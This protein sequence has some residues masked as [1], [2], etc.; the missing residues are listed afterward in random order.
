[1]KKIKKI[2][3][4]GHFGG[5][6]EFFDGQTIKTKV[7]CNTIKK[8]TDWKIKKVDTYLKA[9]SPIKLILKSIG[10]LLSTKRIVVLLSVNGMKFYFPILYFFAKVFRRKIF[11]DV[12]GGNLDV[13][14][15]KNPKFIKYLNS[16]E[17]NWVET[18]SM[19]DSLQSLEINNVKVLPN[20][21]ELDVVKEEELPQE[22][23][24]PFR[25]CT[26]SRVMKEK[27]IEDAIDAIERINRE[28]GR[29]VCTV[30]IYGNVDEGY[31]ERFDEIMKAT[32]SAVK[33]CGAVPFDK[34][35]EAIKEYYGLLFPTFWCGEGFAGTIV[36]AFSA[37]L[38]VIATDFN[39]NSEIVENNITGLLYPNE[40]QKNLY[41]CI[42]WAIENSNDFCKMKKKCINKAREYQP[43]KYIDWIKAELE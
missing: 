41:D 22:F 24:E 34:S 25:F 10:M 4:I 12:I 39:C 35:V 7:F 36:D 11:H 18:Q 6:E 13:L 32:S 37:G 5:T 3:I 2:G 31:I 40:E 42:I 8:H 15:Q 23:P 14:V 16:F 28:K 9:R 27:G 19:K 1:M 29:T 30:D 21:K 38:P 26:F 43:D 17:R 33:F 20:F